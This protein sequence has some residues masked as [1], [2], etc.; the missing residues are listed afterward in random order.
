VPGRS[1]STS[2][3]VAADARDPE[4]ARADALVDACRAALGG[5]LGGVDDAGPP[6]TILAH[7]DQDVL[8]D[9]GAEGCSFID[10]VGAISS[11]TARR[12][13]CSATVHT[14]VYLL[15][16]RVEPGGTTRAVP[17]RL[18]RAV[19][20]RDGGCRFP[21]CTQRRF[22]DV[23]HVVYWSE[24]GATVPSN[25]TSLCRAHH[26]L[27]HEGGFRLAMS[28]DG[29]VQVWGP[30]GAEV[31]PAPP[32]SPVPGSSLEDDHVEGG[33]DLGPRSLAYDGEEMDLGCV[34][35]ALFYGAAART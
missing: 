16:G 29:R 10:G 32:M 11:H 25:L 12:L 14:L 24:G 31:M 22:V 35:D 23:H 21:G 19:L 3:R 9:P 5:G 27:V 33:L 6:V 8:D 18:R 28:P 30:H 34:L 26:R 2:D 13:A 4:L 17:R 20:A 15:D 7:V 1:S